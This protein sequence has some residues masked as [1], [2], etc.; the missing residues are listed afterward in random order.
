MHKLTREIIGRATL[1]AI[2]CPI[3]WAGAK[4]MSYARTMPASRS[5]AAAD[6]IT[7]IAI[8]LLVLGGLLVVAAVVSVDAIARFMGPPPKM[9]LWENPDPVEP[10][11]SGGWRPWW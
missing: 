11:R 6:V 10:T 2:A 3:I 7:C 8:V 5:N 4:C 9:T 1:L